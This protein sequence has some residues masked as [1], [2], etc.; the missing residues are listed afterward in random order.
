VLEIFAENCLRLTEE[1]ISVKNKTQMIQD[2]KNIDDPLKD[3][4]QS[5]LL[6]IQFV[7]RSKYSSFRS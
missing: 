1:A 3:K 5:V 4:P 2:G 7:L 6:K